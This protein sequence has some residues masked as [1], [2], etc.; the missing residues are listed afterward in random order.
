MCP[1][2]PVNSLLKTSKSFTLKSHSAKRLGSLIPSRRTSILPR[3][4][5][6]TGKRML[7][8]MSNT[9][10]N[11][12]T[13][14]T[15]VSSIPTEMS[16][17]TNSST[18]IRANSRNTGIGRKSRSE[19]TIKMNHLTKNGRRNHNQ[20]SQMKIVDKKEAGNRAIKTAVVARGKISIEETVV[21]GTR[22]VVEATNDTMIQD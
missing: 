20:T 9:Q 17:T 19:R 7:T 14:M 16:N 21:V 2:N 18:K 1:S 11:N 5:I 22:E 3:S 4:T 15:M 8:A 13:T 6:I 12:S 10:I